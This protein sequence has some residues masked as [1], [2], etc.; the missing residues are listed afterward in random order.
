M[1][2]ASLLGRTSEPAHANLGPFGLCPQLFS[3]LP[4]LSRPPCFFHLSISTVLFSG[5]DTHVPTCT[6]SSLR[7]AGGGAGRRAGFWALAAG[8]GYH[9]A[10][11][12]L[13]AW[14]IPPHRWK[15]DREAVCLDPAG[16]P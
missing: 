4:F 3:E 15:Q 16:D 2:Q 1:S 10:A 14:L 6:S 12:P 5:S 9:R 8:G 7:A 13:G 11:W